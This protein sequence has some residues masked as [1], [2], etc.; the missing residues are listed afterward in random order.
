M[1][2]SL[3]R[4]VGGWLA[5]ITKNLKVSMWRSV[6]GRAGEWIISRLNVSMRWRVGRKVGHFK[7][8][9]FCVGGWAGGWSKRK[10]RVSECRRAGGR[11]EHLKI[12]SFHVLEGGQEG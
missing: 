8:E 1:K 11:V 4:K 10:L 9:G 5:W 3:H 6:F 7:I 2:A 12:E